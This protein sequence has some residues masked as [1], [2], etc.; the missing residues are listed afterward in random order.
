MKKVDKCV[1]LNKKRK[2]SKFETTQKKNKYKRQSYLT[3]S[4]QKP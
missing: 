1:D 3:L 2:N 4:K